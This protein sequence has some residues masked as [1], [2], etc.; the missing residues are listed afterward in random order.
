[1]KAVLVIIIIFIVKADRVETSYFCYLII[2]IFIIMTIIFVIMIITVIVKT[3]EVNTSLFCYV[4]IISII[5][6]IIINN[7]VI[8]I[9][10]II[11][12]SEVTLCSR[13][14]I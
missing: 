12:A 2:S 11:K 8:F 7:F 10:I 4:F 9:I 3:D 14:N 6:I 13:Y 1:M 5:I